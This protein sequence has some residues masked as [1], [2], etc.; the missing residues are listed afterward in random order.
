MGLLS[1]RH[2]VMEYNPT[3]VFSIAFI[4]PGICRSTGLYR[5]SIRKFPHVD[6]VEPKF[7]VRGPPGKLDPFRQGRPRDER[8]KPP[9]D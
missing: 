8:L 9:N 1:D 4:D 5:N 6:G 2:G 3:T 7:K